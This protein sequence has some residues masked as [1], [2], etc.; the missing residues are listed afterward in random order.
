MPASITT[1]FL[2]MGIITA[3]AFGAAGIIVGLVGIAWEGYALSQA[4]R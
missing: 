1:C 2:L 4:G 3:I